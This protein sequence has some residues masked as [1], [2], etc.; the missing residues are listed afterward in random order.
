MRV[1]LLMAVWLAV[2]VGSDASLQAQGPSMQWERVF[3][4]GVSWGGASVL[5]T[6][7][8]G[9]VFVGSYR[10]NQAFDA[11]IVRT[12]ASGNKVWAR[13]LGGDD[14]ELGTSVCA[15]RDGGFV[16]VGMSYSYGPPSTAQTYAAKIDGDGNEVW[17]NTYAET[18]PGYQSMGESV[19]ELEEGGY[20]IAGHISAVPSESD[21][22]HL[23]RIDENGAFQWSRTI[24]P[25]P[26]LD[27]C[28]SMLETA[29]GD[30]VLAGLSGDSGGWEYDGCVIRTDNIGG[31]SWQRRFG[32]S[33]F[34]LFFSIRSTSDG[35]C[36]LV[37]YTT[38]GLYVV[39]TDAE[40]NEQ[41]S[42]TYVGVDR[43]VGFS[44]C[45]VREGGYVIAGSTFRSGTTEQ[46]FFIRKIDSVGDVLWERRFDG[47]RRRGSWSENG[48]SVIQTRDGGYLLA[49][50]KDDLLCMIKF[51][52]ES[53]VPFRRGDANA[54]GRLN[55]ADAVSI[56]QRLFVPGVTNPID[57]CMDVG[58]ANDDGRFNI[59]DAIT[60][61]GS[62]FAF[63]GPLPPPADACGA[64]PTEDGLSCETFTGCQSRGN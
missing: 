44:V 60:V 28:Y 49:G 16:L 14:P 41:W 13:A 20:V 52:P 64:D 9:Y 11:Y 19:L 57:G 46:E 56:L 21:G 17:A 32:T 37:G 33:T 24:G 27:E 45:E 1:R 29:D 10:D 4:H 25:G 34:A 43:E 23:V 15:T 38:E 31:L 6:E 35:G 48:Y 53:A 61:L 55:V 36:I 26:E 42:R 62:L 58:D 50:C 54:D 47:A 39:K 63:A 8:D 5:Q 7:D 30:Y 51:A 18:W 2:Q 59:A 22:F 12:D 40:A 3:V